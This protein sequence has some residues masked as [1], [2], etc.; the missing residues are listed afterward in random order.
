MD[1]ESYGG[2]GGSSYP[3]L[4]NMFQ[5]GRYLLT[6]ETRSHSFHWHSTA[7]M[8]RLI[9]DI[10]YTFNLHHAI[11]FANEDSP[12]GVT[13]RVPPPPAWHVQSTG[14]PLIDLTSPACDRDLNDLM[15]TM[16][17]LLDIADTRTD[18]QRAVELLP[19][20]RHFRLTGTT[21]IKDSYRPAQNLLGSLLLDLGGNVHDKISTTNLQHLIGALPQLEYLRLSRVVIDN[22]AGQ[23]IRVIPQLK[24]LCLADIRPSISADHDFAGLLSLFDLDVLHIE[25]PASIKGTSPPAPLQIAIELNSEGPIRG[26]HDLYVNCGTNDLFTWLKILTK[27]SRDPQPTNVLHRLDAVCEDMSGAYLIGDLLRSPAAMH[28]HCLDLDL[29]QLCK[30]HPP[31]KCSTPAHDK[32]TMYDS[33]RDQC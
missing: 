6:S 15:S 16:Q 1:K 8:C 23:P 10:I 30:L 11:D 32:Y 33:L 22:D 5:R 12:R 21:I 28:V 13:H 19:D 26:I 3:L 31:G 2:S 20:L 27:A 24:S 29:V 14:V 9:Y 7:A 17:L 4:V 18:L 25:G